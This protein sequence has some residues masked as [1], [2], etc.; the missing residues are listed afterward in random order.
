MPP[1]CHG[2]EV[3]CATHQAALC[4]TSPGLTPYPS[5]QGG[6]CCHLPLRPP[7]PSATSLGFSCLSWGSW[8]AVPARETAWY[9]WV[10]VPTAGDL[11]VPWLGR[12]SHDIWGQGKSLG[13]LAP[14]WGLL[15]CLG[16]GGHIWSCRPGPYGTH[17]R[18]GIWVGGG[19]NAQALHWGRV[20]AWSWGILA[21]SW[22]TGLPFGGLR[23]QS[24]KMLMGGGG[25][26]CGA[27]GPCLPLQVHSS[28]CWECRWPQGR[29]RGGPYIRGGV[30]G[31]GGGGGGPECCPPPALLLGR[32]LGSGAP[33][34]CC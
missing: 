30:V 19:H 18:P 32:T 9:P 3:T 10:L 8:G 15:S 6:P 4:A 11:G 7:P 29:G 22:G 5:P 17:P 34:N 12:C 16:G 20:L 25:G 21:S 24:W 23:P 33:F 1:A 14:D 13:G 28:Q 2:A 31:V 26:G 27:G